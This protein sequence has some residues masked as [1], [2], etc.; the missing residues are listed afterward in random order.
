M[1][2]P[3]ITWCCIAVAMIILVVL[4]ILFATRHSE[5]NH[6]SATV[7]NQRHHKLFEVGSERE[8]FFIPGDRL[9]NNIDYY[10]DDD[11]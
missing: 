6:H 2:V 7:T 1:N 3:L 4:R 10:G 11:D 5:I 9:I 8:E